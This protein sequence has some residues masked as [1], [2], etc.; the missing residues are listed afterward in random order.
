MIR[1]MEKKRLRLAVLVSGRGSNLMAILKNIAQ[2]NLNADIE[3]LISD[4][5]DAAALQKAREAGI[6]TLCIPPKDYPN[7]D[8]Y[9]KRMIEEIKRAGIDIIVLA[10]YMRL[11]GKGFLSAFKHR[12]LNIHPALLPAFTG[13][14]A[15]RQALAYG[16]KYSGCTVHFV[17][18]GMDTGPILN[19]VVVPVYDNDDEE[20]LTQRILAEEHKIYSQSLQLIAEGRVYIDG[21]RVIVKEQING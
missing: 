8:A 20:S 21:R 7:R 10:G 3:L 11:V 6:E 4:K 14:H 13:L 1:V 16:V 9:E 17:D 5:P 19:Q 18:E 15:Q 12:V 2:G